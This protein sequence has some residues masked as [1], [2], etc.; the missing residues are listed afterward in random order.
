MTTNDL[1]LLIMIP[2]ISAFIGWGTNVLAVKMLFRPKKAI[3]FFGLTIQGVFPKRQAKLAD[4]IGEVVSNELLN[5]SDLHNKFENATKKI[6][7]DKIISDEIDKIILNKIPI[8]I[9]MAAVFLNNDIANALK[10]IIAKD[11]KSSLENTLDLIGQGFTENLNIKNLVID[12]VANFSPERLEAII[13][14]V[15]KKEF[16]YIEIFGAI[17]GFLIGI[18]Q[19]GMIYLLS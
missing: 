13:L 17:L 11:I 9:P 14:S 15:M 10:D 1:S 8:L 6:D 3:K 19:I 16:Y 12:K 18:V 4:K 5:S 7:F 2:L